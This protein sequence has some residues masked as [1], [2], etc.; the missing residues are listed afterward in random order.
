[1]SSARQASLFMHRGVID[2]IKGTYVMADPFFA[3]YVREMRQVS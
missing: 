3:R 1:M 2:V